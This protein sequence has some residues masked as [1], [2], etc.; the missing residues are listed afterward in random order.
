MVLIV[1]DTND[2]SSQLVG[3]YLYYS[4]TQISY[5]YSDQF[6]EEFNVFTFKEKLISYSGIWMRRGLHFTKGASR[7]SALESQRKTLDEY[8]H[9]NFE[10]VPN[11]LGSLQAEYNHN[12]LIDLQLAE[13]NELKI[14]ATYLLTTKQ[15]LVEL[16]NTDLT[17]NYITK[18]LKDSIRFQEDNSLLRYGYT[19]RVERDEIDALP[20]TFY[21]S[22]IQE[23]IE[24]EYEVR[25]FYLKGKCYSMAIFSQKNKKTQL[26]YR[27]YDDEYSNRNV[28]CQLEKNVEKK[29]DKLMR[30]KNLNCGSID[31]MVDK[32]GE[33]YFLE[34]NPVGQFGWVSFNCN[35]YL[36]KKIAE[37]LANPKM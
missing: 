21:P 29:I 26:D 25:V 7:N 37:C 22:L 31:L 27:N 14:P 32:K 15:D 13:M 9:F 10:E 18:S 19:M 17:K 23:E 16:V 12:K 35:Y 8:L 34:V 11:C 2:V 4:G 3:E 30:S 5:V 6:F 28:P 33:Y 36:E 1:T 20:V 24:K